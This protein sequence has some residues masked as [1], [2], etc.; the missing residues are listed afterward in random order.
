MIDEKIN[1]KYKDRINSL[2][3]SF[4]SVDENNKEYIIDNEGYHIA[5]DNLLLNL[6]NDLGYNGI[7]EAYGKASEYFWYT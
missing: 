4:I 5:F 6:I 7:V 3:D 1:Q 2:N